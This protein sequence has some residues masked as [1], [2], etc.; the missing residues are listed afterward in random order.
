M[1]MSAALLERT[2][3][4][5]IR[6]ASLIGLSDWRIVHSPEELDQ[7]ENPQLVSL[8]LTGRIDEFREEHKRN[9]ILYSVLRYR[10]SCAHYS[11]EGTGDRDRT[12]R[13]C[14]QQITLY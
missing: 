10:P 11:G 1:T 3:E 6:M 2:E 13:R 12:I 14:N 4:Y 5:S 7:Y 9:S 8:A